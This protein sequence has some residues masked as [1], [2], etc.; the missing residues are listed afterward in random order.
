MNMTKEEFLEV[1]KAVT[2]IAIDNRLSID[3]NPDFNDE[4]D[5]V[6][7]LKTE[8]IDY[9][10]LENPT[11][12]NVCSYLAVTLPK[13]VTDETEPAT[14]Y[15]SRVSEYNY[16]ANQ[17]M[18]VARPQYLLGVKDGRFVEKLMWCIWY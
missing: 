7:D 10:T 11:C 18:T 17:L 15:D 3:F 9:N 12:I 2:N 8:A 13:V 4:L 6:T 16:V 1:A 14:E 5:F